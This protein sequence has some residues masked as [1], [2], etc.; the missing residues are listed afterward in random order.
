MSSERTIR[1][2]RALRGQSPAWLLLNA[3]NGPTILAILKTHLFDRKDR[4][5]LGAS[6]LAERVRGD[7]DLVREG[8]DD[9]PRTAEDYID[10]WVA[11]RYLS[12]EY[13]EG[14]TEERLWLSASAVDA[15]RF[16]EALANPRPSV[17]ESRLSIL[18]QA[19]G[20]LSL[21]SD[22]DP[23]RRLE[24]LLEE[25][26]RLDES[27]EALRA[28]RA[29]VIGDR[30]ALERARDIISLGMTL[31]EDFGRVE[32]RYKEIHQRLR[33]RILES[34]ESLKA[35]L[36]QVFLDLRR[37]HETEEGRTFQAFYSLLKDPSQQDL[38]Q[39]ALEAIFQSPFFASLGPGERHFL[40]RFVDILFSRSVSL[41]KATE[42]FSESLLALLQSREFRERRRI[43]AL[44]SDAQ[45]LASEL[46]GQVPPG[47]TL[48]FEIELP[49]SALDS[50]SRIALLDRP[51]GGEAV[52]IRKAG[53]PG[54]D[55]GALLLSIQTDEIDLRTL[56]EN[57]LAV[58]GLLPKASVGDVLYHFPA[59]EG[60]GSVVGLM[61][62]AH[63]H[64]GREDGSETVGW[65]GLD[66][67]H[68][69]AAID[70]WF[71]YR[72]RASELSA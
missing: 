32:E 37:L 48:A 72:E 31:A 45:R 69:S 4:R 24:H 33:E 55:L 18:I 12:R 66:D 13:L 61:H 65:L 14:D 1:A 59:S 3:T 67:V 16:V 70:K 52:P 21:D 36:D 20:R 11:R 7:L 60:L 6:A 56:K 43:G 38:L 54:L 58:L 46:S 9:Y 63:L 40:R 29:P 17:T 47:R 30:E 39:G 53:D 8:P 5:S 25:R 42:R 49:S 15:I 34:G 23:S 57:I 64:G 26:A 19:L 10:D 35:V 71:F 28:G 44:L 27:I 22:P 68:R 62:L 50:V 2:Y 41:D 51:P